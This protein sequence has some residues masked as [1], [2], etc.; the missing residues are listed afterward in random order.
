M[1]FF[2]TA[3]G[4]AYRFELTKTVYSNGVLTIYIDHIE[5]GMGHAALVDWFAI[6]EV[7][8]VPA[9]TEIIIKVNNRW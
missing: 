3:A 9:N 8:K 1:T 2:V 4:G 5:M 7:E 6:V